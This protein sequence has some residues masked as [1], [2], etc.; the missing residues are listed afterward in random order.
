MSKFKL[1]PAEARKL[2]VEAL[3]S[4]KYQQGREVLRRFDGFDHQFCCLG[5]ACDLFAAHEGALSWSLTDSFDGQTQ[6]L[7]VAVRNW[8]GLRD[9]N[10][11]Y[12]DDDH[13]AALDAHNDSGWSFESIADII[14]SEPDGLFATE[15]AQ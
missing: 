14:E 2:W 12:G 7:P 13:H 9:R 8:L 11:S 10:G 1:K 6:I 3:R 15:A 4:G 5:V